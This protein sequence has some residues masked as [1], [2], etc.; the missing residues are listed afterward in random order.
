MYA[1]VLINITDGLWSPLCITESCIQCIPTW[2]LTTKAVLLPRYFLDG[3][4]TKGQCGYKYKYLCTVFSI[5]ALVGTRS[6]A[7]GFVS[8]LLTP[9]IWLLSY[10]SADFL[11][12]WFY[13]IT[14]NTSG[15][16]SVFN[17]PQIC[18]WF[19]NIA[20][21]TQQRTQRKGLVSVYNLEG[22]PVNFNIDLATGSFYT[23]R[24]PNF[25]FT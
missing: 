5:Q 9:V 7:L 18:N 25:I 3:M 11:L 1:C 22:G 14:E 10:N 17:W 21:S 23:S 24:N 20:V 2:V 16:I 13:D 8:P 12:P 19:Q 4:Y 6:H 15:I